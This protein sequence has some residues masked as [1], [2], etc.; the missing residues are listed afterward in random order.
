LKQREKAGKWTLKI[1]F[2]F[3]AF[4]LQTLK[5]EEEEEKNH[6]RDELRMMSS[7][8]NVNL[9]RRRCGNKSARILRKKALRVFASFFCCY[10]GIILSRLKL[11]SV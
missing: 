2:S 11:L 6:R 5:K 10:R 8:H 7:N 3:C 9:L 1:K 4:A